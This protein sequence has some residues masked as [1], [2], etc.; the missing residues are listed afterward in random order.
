MLKNREKPIEVSS[1]KIQQ[2]KHSL[3]TYTTFHWF[4]N[5]EL[6]FFSINVSLVSSWKMHRDG[7]G[8]WMKHHHLQCFAAPALGFRG[9]GSPRLFYMF[10]P[11]R[12]A[13]NRLV[14]TQITWWA[15]G[16]QLETVARETLLHVNSSALGRGHKPAFP[17]LAP[18]LCLSG[19]HPI[20]LCLSLSVVHQ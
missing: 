5:P 9:A 14:R 8:E 18:L 11:G 3:G 20:S 10:L 2:N 1:T 17:P 12:G 13:E 4:C 16:V 6:S 19:P 15:D 7:L